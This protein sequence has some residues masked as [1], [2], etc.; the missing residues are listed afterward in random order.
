MQGGDY[1]EEQLCEQKRVLKEM[2]HWFMLEV[3]RMN[4]DMQQKP[5]VLEPKLDF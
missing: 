2:Y 3:C 5:K 4:S 1:K